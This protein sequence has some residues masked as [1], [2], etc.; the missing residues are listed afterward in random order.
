MKIF[1]NN[2]NKTTVYVQKKDIEYLAYKLNIPIGGTIFKK[3]YGDGLRLQTEEEQDSFIEFTEQAEIEFFKNDSIILDYDTVKDLDIKGVDE[4]ILECTMFLGDC[5]SDALDL[6]FDGPSLDEGE[7][8]FESFNNDVGSVD[9][10]VEKTNYMITSLIEYKNHLK[11]TKKIKLPD[12][13]KPKTLRFP[14]IKNPF[15]KKK[16][17]ENNEKQS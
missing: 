5:M 9:I 13:I 11:G 1:V 2:N 3:T 10:R 15:A 16:N 7:E 8:T 4:K 14:K 17:N 6:L 12:A